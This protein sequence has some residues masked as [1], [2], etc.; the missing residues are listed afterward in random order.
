MKTSRRILA[1]AAAALVAC[2]SAQ[3]ATYTWANSN[4]TGTPA[5]PLNWFNA[6]QGAW[7]GG[8][9]V[10]GN[11]TIQFF[12]DATTALT[13][14]GSSGNTQTSNIDNGASAFQLGVLTLAGKA[15]ATTGANLT[16]TI[17]GDPLNF[18]GAT[19]TINLDGVNNTR[20]ITYNLNSNIQLGTASSANVLTVQG[21]GTGTFAI[22]GNIT[23]LQTGGGSLVKSG[24]STVTLSG[25]NSFTG[26]TSIN[27]GTVS[28]SSI[29]NTGSAGNLGNVSTI[30]IGS[31]NSTATLTYSG[32]G[33][34]TNR[35]I[36]LA[37]ATG[38]ATIN[39]TSN[40]TLIFSSNV[41]ATGLG[42]KTLT[43]TGNI[44]GTETLQGIVTDSSGGT[45]AVVT[46]NF[47]TGVLSNIA[48]SFTGG[49]TIGGKTGLTVSTISTTGNNSSIG[50]G[51]GINF[52][53]TS[54]GAGT[55]KV[56]GAGGTTDRA[57]TITN[58][59]AN[60]TGAIIDSSGSGAINFTGSISV[61]NSAANPI[62]TLALQGTSALTNT[63]SGNITNSPDTT[64]VLNVVRNNTVGPIWVLSGTGNTYTGTTTISG[65]TLAGI[66]ANA[67]GSTSGISIAAAN[68][69]TLSLLGDSS[70]SFVKASDSSSYA[71]STTASGATINADKA[72]GAGTGAKTMT[73]GSV[74]T[75][76]TAATYQ[77]NFTGGNNTSL[78][79]GAVTG[80]ASIAAGNVTISNAIAG[81]GSLTLASYTSNN[82]AGGETLTFSGVGNTTITGA[83]TPSSTV[84]NLKQNGTG[85]VTLSGTNTY[86]GNTT[87]STG[88]LLING[89]SSAA[90]GNLTVSANATLGGNGKIGGAVNISAAGATLAPGTSAVPAGT[91]TLNNTN[92]SFS[93]TNSKLALDITG[94]STFDQVVGIAALALNGD[95]TITLSGTYG[96][97]SWNLLS[98][99]SESG[100]FHSITLAGSYSGTLTQAGNIWSNP[101]IGGDSWSFDQTNG[102]LTSAVP[103]PATWALLAFSLTTV[104]VLRR[105]RTC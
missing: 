7:T 51:G 84:L 90:T 25:A 79:V 5:S 46:S 10:S 3:A 77:I 102:T 44:G 45:T 65:G 41:T 34:T 4:V 103:E 85:V 89:D 71:V 74:G 48:N 24:S 69:A 57:I 62:V 35:A 67:F 9:P 26:G 76:S 6:T 18:S 28:V 11:N 96:N 60:T 63:I 15:S 82:T 33:E 47:M 88:T 22:G 66:G 13:N 50:A 73:I 83:I 97:A 23:E 61:L 30:N 93:N 78:S 105:R 1:F 29:G 12:Q 20:T 55:L 95:V 19:G 104:M 99:S 36:N 54:S 2:Q 56:T 32:V 8:T 14:N 40:G 80:A 98:F 39:I 52:L 38:G 100:N 49:I 91:L 64:K 42:A 27:A 70:T 72:T 101:S 31:G 58:A 53:A 68:A 94:T 92:L 43:L 81:G 21:N 86:T 75:T 59:N 37:G 87:V 16:M 17:S